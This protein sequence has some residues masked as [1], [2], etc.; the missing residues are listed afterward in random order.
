MVASGGAQSKS[1]L[2]GRDG[3]LTEEA[4]SVLKALC[5]GAKGVSLGRPILY[6]QACYGQE[7][8]ERACQSKVSSS[9][10]PPKK[11]KISQ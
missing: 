2:Q 5:L 1:T 11:A 3:R 6:A 7:G 9:T 8:I 4:F 10:S